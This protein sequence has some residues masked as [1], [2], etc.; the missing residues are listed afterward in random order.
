[1]VQVVDNGN[2][3]CACQHE[4]FGCSRVAVAFISPTVNG[5]C[6]RNYLVSPRDM[7][8]TKTKAKERI[9]PQ[10]S[11]QQLR[12]SCRVCLSKASP[13]DKAP[14]KDVTD[15]QH[16]D[17]ANPG[18]ATQNNQTQH[19]TRTLS[20]PDWNNTEWFGYEKC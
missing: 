16:S 20:V 10:G 11:V 8:T 14:N 17:L 13:M 7:I 4:G 15:L 3:S 2:R 9:K 18:A 6:Y 12:F 19:P 5:C 1:M